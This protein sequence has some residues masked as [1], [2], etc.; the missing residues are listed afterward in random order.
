MGKIAGW[1]EVEVGASSPLKRPKGSS[2]SVAQL[3]KLVEELKHL[4]SGLDPDT[5]AQYNTLIATVNGHINNVDVHVTTQIKS[6]IVALL[7]AYENGDLGGSG[8]GATVYTNRAAILAATGTVGSIG[9]VAT[10]PTNLYV[11]HPTAN[12][13]TVRDGNIYTTLAD[14]PS[15]TS[16]YIPNGTELILSSTGVKY[17]WIEPPIG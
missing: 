2:V 7:L 12:R 4:I 8:G 11:W 17:A 9:I 13:W 5:L 14:V 3:I 16:F 15:S 6:N 1:D 10:E